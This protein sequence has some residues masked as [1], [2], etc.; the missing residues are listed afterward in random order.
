[1][2]TSSGPP[3]CWTVPWLMSCQLM[4]SCTMLMRRSGEA[5]SSALARLCRNSANIAPSALKP[6]VFTLAMLLATTSSSRCSAVC[7]D[8]PMRSAFSIDL[9]SPCDGGPPSQAAIPSIERR[10]PKRSLGWGV[11]EPVPKPENSYDIKMLHKICEAAASAGLA[12]CRV[13]PGKNYR[14]GGF[15]E[16]IH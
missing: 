1:M 2:A 10:S 14:L 8:R 13:Q 5:N 6:V 16:R 9:N 4:R 12:F 3:V 7:R 11:A 15:R